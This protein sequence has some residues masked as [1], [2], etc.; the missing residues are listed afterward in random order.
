MLLQLHLFFFFVQYSQYDGFTH[1][2][3]ISIEHID[4]GFYGSTIVPI[5]FI[6]SAVESC[7]WTYIIMFGCFS[8]R[9][10]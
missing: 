5:Y 8:K 6:T 2:V 7:R 4:N 1:F 10:I 9:D 3:I